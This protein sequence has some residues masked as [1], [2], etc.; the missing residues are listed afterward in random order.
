M[1]KAKKNQAPVSFKQFE[2]KK[3]NKKA[4]HQI[5]GGNGD[6]PPPDT[7]ENDNVV[8]QDIMNV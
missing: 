2:C 6:T 4:A 8:T 1:K 5:K 3:L 7:D